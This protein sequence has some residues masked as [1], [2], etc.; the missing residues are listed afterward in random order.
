MPV[1]MLPVTFM[2]LPFPLFVGLVLVPT[3]T[4]SVS[5]QHKRNEV[6]DQIPR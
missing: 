5:G 2:V 4:Y 3:P 1:Y 6:Y